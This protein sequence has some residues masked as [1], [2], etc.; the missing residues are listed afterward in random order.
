TLLLAGSSSTSTNPTNPSFTRLAVGFDTSGAELLQSR[1]RKAK[2]YK[3][4][5][6]TGFNVMAKPRFPEGNAVMFVDPTRGR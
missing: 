5:N 4:F 3:A 2:F 6:S 1:A